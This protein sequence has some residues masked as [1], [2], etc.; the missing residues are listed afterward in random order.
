M[1]DIYW[2]GFCGNGSRYTA[3]WSW[4]LTVN[5]SNPDVTQ[6]FQDTVFVWVSC[7]IFWLFALFF[8]P[9]LSSKPTV[10][11][12]RDAGKLNLAKMILSILLCL[13]SIL[14]LLKSFSEIPTHQT[15]PAAFVAPAIY[16][17][18]FGMSSFVITY[19]FK[20]GEVSSAM[21]FIFWSILLL[22]GGVSLRSKII[23]V[24][25]QDLDSMFRVV[26]FCVHYTCIVLEFI[27]HLW[28][29]AKAL[30]ESTPDWGELSEKQPILI[31]AKP[32]TKSS[33]NR[34]ISP[35]IRSSFLS[36][37]LYWWITKL[38]IKG[39]KQALVFADMYGLLPEDSCD[40]ILPKF[41]GEWRKEKVKMNNSAVR[42]SASHDCSGTPNGYQSHQMGNGI[43]SAKT[44][45]TDTL[46]VETIAS[47]QGQ[48]SLLMA[49]LRTFGPYYAMAALLRLL[50]DAVTFVN[51]MLL[52]LMITFVETGDPLTWRGYLLA[53]VMFL[54]SMIRSLLN[55]N[56]M[57]ICL[58]VGLRARTAIIATVYRKSLKLSSAARKKSTVGEIVNLMSVDAQKMQESP[59]FLHLIWSS[60]IAII[61]ALVLLWEYLGVATLAGLV[62]IILLIPLNAYAG[63]QIRAHQVTQMSLKDQRL[64]VLNEVLNAIKILKLYA[65]E[66][67]FQSK[68]TGIRDTELVSLRNVQIANAFTSIIWFCAPLL[69]ALASFAT[70]VLS[71]PNNVLDPNTAFV[72][73]SLFTIVNSYVSAVP[74]SIMYLVQ[75]GVS[76]GRLNRFLKEEELDTSVVDRTSSANGTI[77][78]TDGTFSWDRD[79]PTTLQHINIEI[80]PGSLVAVV[81]QVGSGKSSLLNALL[82][83]M[84]R[85]SGKINVKGSVAYV[86][87][88]AWIQNKTVKENILFGKQWNQSFYKKCLRTCALEQDLKILPAG[89]QTEIGEK[90]VNL[91][92]GQKQR[93]SL[94][95]AVYQDCDVY[96]M[97]D[98][99]SAVDSHV[100]KHIFDHVIGPEGL[101]QGKTR[102]LTTN[103]ISFLPKVD[104]IIVLTKG[105]ISEIGTYQELLSH[106]GAFAE[107]IKNYLNE[108]ESESESE[109]EEDMRSQLRRQI[110]VLSGSESGSEQDHHVRKRKRQISRQ[111]SKQTSRQTSFGESTHAQ[112]V[113]KIGEQLIEEEYAERGTVK[114]TH[115][116]SYIRASGLR[117]ILM[118]TIGYI[119]FVSCLIGANIWLNLWSNDQVVNGTQQLTDLRLGVYGGLGAGQLSYIVVQYFGI[120][121]GCVIA[122]GTIHKSFL[123]RI[124]RAPMSFFDTTPLGRIMNRFSKDMETVDLNL[125]HTVE[126]ILAA[127]AQVIAVVAVVMYSTPIFAVVLL[128]LGVL[129]FMTQKLYLSSARQFI[130][131][132]ATKRSPI[133][134]HFGETLIGASSIRAY[135]QQERFMQLTDKMIDDNQMAWYGYIMS[136]RWCG[137]LMETYGCFVI[138]FAAIFAVLA[139]GSGSITGG[140]AG[141]SISLSL[142]V[143]QMLNYLVRASCD[144]EIQVVAIERI[145]EYSAVEVEAPWDIDHRRPPPE[146]PQKGEVQ[147]D[148]Y[149]VRYRP[150]LDLVLK[151]VTFQV[152][153]GEKVGIVGRTGAGKSSLTLALFRII[154]SAAGSITID[155][156]KIADIGLHQLRS[157]I[158]IIP[159]EPELFSGTLRSN[160]DPF[161]LY[162]DQDVWNAL[163]HAHLKGFVA[164]LPARLQHEISEAGEN[165]S[166][167]QRQLVCLAR[168]LLR[169][170]K[171]LVL[172][173]ATA[174]VDMETDDLIQS[175]IRSEFKECT[176]VTIA[177]RLNTIM[178]Y[179]RVLVLDKGTI[180]EFQP[181][182]VLLQDKRSTF[183]GMAKDAGLV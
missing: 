19:E 166:V 155:G 65:W 35:E 109:E 83:D 92:G 121:F 53:V 124:M 179:D 161:G 122:S 138:L 7:G 148:Q 134:S 87:Q 130:R 42:F 144:F 176:V 50:F 150:G 43:P 57:R 18:T 22:L 90:G 48:P 101:L 63:T 151:N 105:V 41:L 132:D 72:S 66:E 181:P 30:P 85:I 127:S 55:Q 17:F 157:K 146:W 73:L 108:K 9:V 59:I 16:A 133:Y 154:E 56:Y 28:A 11:R 115:M 26:T 51:P 125:P 67:S 95:R 159:Q 64:K 119:G 118:V 21:L 82:G 112:E 152:E 93:V 29:D 120:A 10:H 170:T 13:T 60:A 169:K 79:E 47:T 76:I 113:M 104:A 97:D 99:L 102:I 54:V 153:P 142:N 68:V 84:E 96:L 3:F 123:E 173:E 44:T 6:C 171:I 8:I 128:P 162:S 86:P 177:H 175:T 52:S 32:P 27:L 135:Q 98:P 164:T 141:M 180:K 58:R 106:N 91:S 160:L 156:V 80:P 89:D 100:G 69:M 15:P 94:A 39:Y 114:Y 77:S 110:S 46:H 158:T 45:L 140:D 163:E 38:V 74:I 20:K 62:V 167:G 1:E 172:D 23:Q 137:V 70:F 126:I 165:L 145:Q 81:G 111:T 107:F 2:P 61:V 143:T 149:S 168:A 40:V 88:Q 71:D 37:I 33:G 4:S 147:F 5:T 182:S 34:E 25:I 12:M 49:L 136:N 174:A 117:A 31:K 183:Y 36:R 116:L 78:V 178:D 24:Q 14:D 131:I 75:A 139:T 103:G 129:Y